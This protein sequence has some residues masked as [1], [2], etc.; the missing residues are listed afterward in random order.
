MTGERTHGGDWTG[1][2]LDFSTN[3]VPFGVPEGALRAVREAAAWSDRYPDPLCREL[4]SAIGR[5]EGVPADRILC[6]DGAADLIFRAVLAVRPRRAVVTA[7]AFT[8][9]EAALDA[10]G[11]GEVVRWPLRAETGFRLDR[12]VLDA[13]TPGTDLIF[14]CQPDNPTGVTI[15]RPLL[16]EILGRCREVGCLLVMD[17]CF[18]GLLDDPGAS[19]LI[20][21]LDGGPGLLILRAFTKLYGMAGIRLGYALCADGGLLDAM[22]RSGQPWSVSTL[23]QAAGIAA[24]RETAYVERARALIRAERPRLTA[25]LR[26][27][28]LDVIPGEANYLLFRSPSPLT[29][30]LRERGILI[31]ECGDFAGLDDTWYRTA[32]RTEREDGRLIAALREVLG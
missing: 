1:R 14:L 7:P 4:R 2:L 31:R 17:E 22:R 8:E 18:V 26:D 27:L 30:P 19:T 21:E 15:P 12:E 32:V 9:Y 25:A 5:A 29:G 23:A 10:A 24:L 16:R 20:G 6:G 11:C 3:V 28:G 13:V